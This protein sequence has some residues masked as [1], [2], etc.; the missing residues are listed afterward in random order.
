MKFIEKCSFDKVVFFLLCCCY[1]YLCFSGFIPCWFYTAFGY[2]CAGCGGCH[3]VKAILAGDLVAAF[4]YNAFILVTAVP[5]T[6]AL[7]FWKRRRSKLLVGYGVAL[8]L[9]SI[10]RNIGGM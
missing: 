4:K 8:L 5:I 7:C 6:I 1:I 2:K 3:M 9:W 10:F